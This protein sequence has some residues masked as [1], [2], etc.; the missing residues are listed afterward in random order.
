MK[1]KIDGKKLN[2]ANSVNYLGI[3]IDPHLNWHINAIQLYLKLS[4]SIGML[5]KIRHFVDHKTL[6]M[7]Y[8]GI[9]SSKLLY[10]SQ[11]WGQGSNKSIIKIHKLQNKA[12]RII[13]FKP[14]NAD[15]NELYKSTKIL[16]L[17]DSIKLNNFLFSHDNINNNLPSVLLNSLVAVDFTK[18]RSFEYRQLKIPKVRT[19]CF[20]TNSIKSKSV[21]IWNILNKKFHEEKFYSKSKKGCKIFISQAFL[22]EY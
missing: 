19:K 6:I 20:G 17:C 12:L 18:T 2:P 9:F 22:D 7:I 14:F 4:R 5:S 11:I 3:T 8:H 1:I 10:G 13:N 16:K 21:E 15:V